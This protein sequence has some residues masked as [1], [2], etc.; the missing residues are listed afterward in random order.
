[1]RAATGSGSR[2][3]PRSCSRSTSCHRPAGRR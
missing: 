1:M 2:I 3:V